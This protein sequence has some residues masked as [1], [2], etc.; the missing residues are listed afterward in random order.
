MRTAPS[1]DI[2]ANIAGIVESYE[3]LGDYSLRMLAQEE[4]F[5][6]IRVYT[7]TGRQGH[8][9]MVEAGFVPF[10]ANLGPEERTHMLDEL[11][12]ALDKH[13]RWLERTGTL[14]TRRRERL[15]DRTREVVGRH[16]LA[17][18]KEETDAERRIAERLDEIAAGRVSPYEVAGEVL[19]HLRQGARA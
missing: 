4:R 1:G 7:D 6:V 12:T 19:D 9:Q 8:R 14:L 17:W 15:R 2:R 10:L 18:L 11:V 13:H 3:R 16:A 5:E